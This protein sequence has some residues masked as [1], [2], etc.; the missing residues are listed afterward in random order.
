MQR[1]CARRGIA[2]TIE[3]AIMRPAAATL[4]ILTTAGLSLAF[5]DPPATPATPVAPESRSTPAQN[6]TAEDSTGQ[7]SAAHAVPETAAAPAAE[8]PAVAPA[9]PTPSAS[10][11][12]LQEQLLRSQGYKLSMVNGQ[13]KYCRR[14]IP[15]GS[16]LATVFHCMTVAEAQAMAKEGRE[17]TERIQRSTAGCLNPAQGGCGK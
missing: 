3:D 9:K 17:T 2:K 14:E 6:S 5:A 1:W 15:L 11:E 7:N 4:A 13:E 12:R 8:T 16:H 10:A